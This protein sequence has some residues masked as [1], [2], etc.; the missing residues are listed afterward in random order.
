MATYRIDIRAGAF[1]G[2]GEDRIRARVKELVDAGI[3]FL[4][5]SQED[6]PE[7]ADAPTPRRA[8]AR[9]PP[10]ADPSRKCPKCGRTFRN[11]R[12]V[13]VHL[14]RAHKDAEG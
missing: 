1:R 8:G 12:G 3:I 10:P 5:V 9:Q 2:L 11:L 6:E 4:E 13:E 14:S 7:A